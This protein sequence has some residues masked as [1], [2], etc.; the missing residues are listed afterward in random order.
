M[1]MMR[2]DILL[3]LKGSSVHRSNGHAKEEKTRSH[4][5]VSNT[6]SNA[7]SIFTRIP[8]QSVVAGHISWVIAACGHFTKA[9][10][11]LGFSE[12]V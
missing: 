5:R 6:S 9:W 12:G 3:E 10:G 8:Y 2:M 4:A 1:M 11:L 7:I